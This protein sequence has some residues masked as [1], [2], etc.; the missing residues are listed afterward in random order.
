MAWLE[1]I[2]IRAVGINR[3]LLK[4]QLQDI[5]IDLNKDAELKSVKIYKQF[6]LE[7]DFSIH[8][9]HDS[10]NPDTCCSII[11]TKLIPSLKDFGLVNHTVWI[12]NFNGGDS[13]E[14]K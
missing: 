2:E 4:S 10:E 11:C 1:I 13:S 8:L 3:E 7:T 5:I 12:E 9:F 6:M 14:S